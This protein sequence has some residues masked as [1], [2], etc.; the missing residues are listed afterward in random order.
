[1]CFQQLRACQCGRNSAYLG[2]RDNVLA[3]EVL[4]NLYCPECRPQDESLSKDMIEDGGWVLEYDLP[5]AQVFFN[6]RGFPH[7][8]NPDFI[9]DE[10]YLSWQGLAP[11]DQA[12]NNELHHRLAPLVQEDLN[13]YLQKLKEEWL[14]HVAQLKAAGWRK[15]QRT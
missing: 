10:G 4:V 12:F 13:L 11:G 6:R 5:A 15:A 1:M 14:A 2:Y 7:P 3:P 9:F 8:V